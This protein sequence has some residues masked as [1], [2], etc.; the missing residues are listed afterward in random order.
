[1]RYLRQI[2][3]EVSDSQRF[4]PGAKVFGFLRRHG[5]SRAG[6]G[7]DELLAAEAAGN[8]LVAEAVHQAIADGAQDRVAGVMAVIV[9][10]LLEVVDVDRENADTLLSP[11]RARELPPARFH[12]VA[13]IEHAGQRIAYRLIAQL[14]TQF[15]V[16]DGQTDLLCTNE[17]QPA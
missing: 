3:F 17:A 1:Y 13:P 16:G 4:H 2:A 12:H 9:V 7:N 15:H 11:R 10:E 8:V 14:I 6:Q 5:R